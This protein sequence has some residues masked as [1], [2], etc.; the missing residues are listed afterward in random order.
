MQE[1]ITARNTRRE[2][3]ARWMLREVLDDPEYEEATG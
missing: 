1:S 2:E 3:Y